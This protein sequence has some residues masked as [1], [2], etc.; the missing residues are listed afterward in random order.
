MLGL[1]DQESSLRYVH[2]TGRKCVSFVPPALCCRSNQPQPVPR[3]KTY[4]NHTKCPWYR[5]DWALCTLTT[6]TSTIFERIPL[7]SYRRFATL[8]PGRCLSSSVAPTPAWPCD[9]S[10]AS[11]G[12]S[13]QASPTRMSSP[14]GGFSPACGMPSS[15]RASGGPSSSA[16]SPGP[17][18]ACWSPDE[19][20]ALSCSCP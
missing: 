19:R 20:A 11:A 7:P 8:S 15:I 1:I 2:S 16:L 4:E 17:D 13:D 3:L 18:S 9:P 10:P 12:V 6:S 14:G 5:C